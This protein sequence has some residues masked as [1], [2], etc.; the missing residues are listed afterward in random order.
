M[1]MMIMTHACNDFQKQCAWGWLAADDAKW[2]NA[3][4]D[5]K[6]IKAADDA[7]WMKTAK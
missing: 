6:W 3:A 7:R 2:I 5:A 4:D 1:T